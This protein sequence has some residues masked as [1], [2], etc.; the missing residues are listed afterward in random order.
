VHRLLG[1]TDPPTAVFAAQHMAGRGTMRAM[2]RSG[3]Q[4]DL[5]VFDEMVDTDLL[6]TP[7][8]VVVASGPDR[9]GSLGATMVMERLDGLAGPARS[10]VLE[11]LFVEAL[12]TR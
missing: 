9:L 12:V 11:P 2:R 8:V 5:A 4:L 6:V 3:V 10:V 1:L 7:P